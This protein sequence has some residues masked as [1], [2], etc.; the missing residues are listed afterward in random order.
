MATE[1][2]LDGNALFPR[3]LIPVIA[4]IIAVAFGAISYRQGII[5]S[6]DT[7]IYSNWADI[8]IQDHFNYFRFAQDAQ[9]V[10]SP[11]L[12]LGW[13]TVVALFKIVLGPAWI[14]GIVVFNYC[15]ALTTTWW[16][17]KLIGRVTLSAKCV[18]ASGAFVLVAYEMFN[19][20]RF[21]LSDI[22]F[23]T[24]TFA[25]FYLLCVLPQKEMDRK[26]RYAWPKQALLIPLLLLILFYRPAALPV[27]FV[28]A[29]AYLTR[30]KAMQS[31]QDRARLVKRAAVVLSVVT[32]FVLIA[33]AYLMMNPSLWPTSFASGWIQRLSAEYHDGWIVYQRPETYYL[34][35]TSSLDF[36]I[37]TLIKLAY[38]FSFRSATFSFA[39]NLADMVFFLP[40]YSLSLLA[41]Y[42]LFRR[43]RSLTAQAWW[44]GWLSLLWIILYALFHA[45]QEI[46]YDW[47]YRLICM[48]QLIVLASVGLSSLLSRK[49]R[50][51]EVARP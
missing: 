11:V 13:V 36:I 14:T 41:A 5:A 33:H 10:I 39:H 35:P 28:V 31:S 6:T 37:I 25:V 12:Y 43:D 16:M 51:E 21:A 7:G 18:A 49:S 44:C 20:I 29:I 50:A 24:L 47:R 1:G 45:L 4:A 8:L 32:L 23:M 9:F 40:V 42:K 17:L 3:W 34:N 22:S 27:L 15:L 38:F 30:G 2:P 19:W 46:D 26:G 48:P